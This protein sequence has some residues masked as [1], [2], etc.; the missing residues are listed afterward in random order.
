[1]SKIRYVLDYG[2]EWPLRLSNGMRVS[3]KGW[4]FYKQNRVFTGDRSWGVNKRLNQDKL[5]TGYKFEHWVNEYGKEELAKELGIDR[6]TLDHWIAR[7]HE[8]RTPQIQRLKKMSRGKLTYEDIIDRATP[9]FIQSRRVR[10]K[11]R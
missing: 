4:L 1:M 8:P 9:E 5:L 3:R 2:Y 7:R 6:S 11:S 10:K